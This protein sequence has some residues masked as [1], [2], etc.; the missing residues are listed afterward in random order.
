MV[1][2]KCGA[3]KCELGQEPT[4]AL[5]IEHLVA[6]FD[7]VRRVLRKDG[8]IFVNLGD[9]YAGSGKGPSGA[10]GI[11]DQE[12]RQGFRGGSNGDFNARS[13]NAVGSRKQEAGRNR[14]GL[15][16]V[17]G[18]KPKSLLLIPE[19]FAISMQDA[20]WV[21]RS[22][23]AW[24]KTSAMPESVRDRPTS[25]WEHIWMFTRQ[26]RYF[27]DQE[28]TRQP[29]T[30]ADDPRNRADYVPKRERNVGGRTDG[31]TSSHGAVGWNPAGANLRNFWLLG[32]EPS[33]EQH[34]AAFPSEIPRRCILA[35]TS[36]KGQCPACGEPWARVVERTVTGRGAT[37]SAL[38]DGLHD[39]SSSLSLA[40][41]RQAY[42]A[43]GQEGPPPSKH[44]GWQPSCPCDAGPPTP[45][46]VLDP[47]L[48][49]GT[50]ALVADQLGRNAIGIELQPDYV[51]I[52]RRRITNDGPMFAD[53]TVAG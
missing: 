9:S 10:N 28:A 46:L 35:A 7:E 15:G 45:Q 44:L 36:E 11:G 25:A 38:S 19:R 21:V 13:G 3:I 50:T 20:G 47:F 40:Q 12:Q 37:T 16:G 4:P 31:Y 42:R 5:F 23:I 43:L 17:A 29:N 6:I 14:D 41:K 52:S 27:W 49:S 33:R 53:V 48:G 30:S 34:Y 1:C 8:C 24:C 22:R 18:V 26:A 51:E 39:R 32:P 2:E